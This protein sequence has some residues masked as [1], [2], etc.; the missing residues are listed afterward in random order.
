MEGKVVPGLEKLVDVVASGIGSVAG[1]MLAPWR[2][3][4]E[5]KAREIAAEGAARVLRIQAQAQE[6]ARR[7]LVGEDVSR[8]VEIELAE[9]IKQRIEYQEHKRQANITAVVGM[10]AQRLEQQN[11][12]AI[13][14]DHDWTARFF[15]EVQDVSS[16][17]MQ[18]LWGR[19]LAGEVRRPGTT[20]MRTLGILRDLDTATARLFSRFSSAAVYL[21]GPEDEVFDARV[22]SLGRNAAQNSLS[23]YG[24]GFGAL[25]RLNEHGLIIADYNS[26][27]TYVVAKHEDESGIELLHQGVSWDWVIGQPDIEEKTMLL[28]GVAMTVAGSELS[29]FVSL[30][31]MH[32]YT[33]VL[34]QFL[35]QNFKLTMERLDRDGTGG[36]RIEG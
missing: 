10:A 22:L 19:I 23:D 14:P 5:S 29:K 15:G 16:E 34:Q 18:V 6:K 1:P 17:E 25:N 27:N 30:E 8:K 36:R 12:P 28:H 21:K 26:Y 3:R 13:E 33:K 24:F 2:A 35:R 7:V 11:V 32:A 20:S 31:P 4:R 9:G